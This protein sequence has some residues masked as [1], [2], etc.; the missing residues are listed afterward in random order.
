MTQRGRFHTNQVVGIKYC[1]HVFGSMI[2]MMGEPI[3]NEVGIKFPCMCSI[4]T[5]H[6]HG[7]IDKESLPKMLL[8][9]TQQRDRCKIN[10]HKF[11]VSSD[12]STCI[13]LCL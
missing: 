5:G 2:I 11:S 8:G 7:N 1:L 13:Y 3:N 4:L 9:G 6:S 12:C 10:G